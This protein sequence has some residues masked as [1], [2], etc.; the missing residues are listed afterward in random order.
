LLGA[1]FGVLVVVA[2]L[3]FSS[4]L[5]HLVSTPARYGWTW[6]L[7]GYDVKAGPPSG[8][9]CGPVETTLT[10]DPSF[11]G[12]VGVHGRRRGGRAPSAAGASS[13]CAGRCSPRSSPAASPV[14][15]GALGA[16][17]LAALDEHVG[18]H[19]RA[20]GES[21]SGTF[22]IV[23]QAVLSGISDPESMADGAACSPRRHSIGWAQAVAG[24]SVKLAGH[25]P[26]AAIRATQGAVLGGPITSTLPAEIDRVHQ[27]RSL[28]VA[29]AVFVAVIALVAVGLALVSSR[30]AGAASSRCS[31]HWA[32]RAGRYAPRSRQAS[33]VAAVGLVIG[34]PLG[35]L[36][37]T[38]VWR[39]VAEELGVAPDPCGRCSVSRCSSSAPSS[40]STCCRSAG[41]RRT[42]P[43][44]SRP[45]IGM[46]W[47]PASTT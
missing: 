27:I 9:D 1:A 18:G 16:E 43:P 22:R 33:T 6:D 11:S 28:P 20:A 3:M 15:R 42:H 31:R 38:F 24:T 2:V 4:G 7:V 21:E 14:R 26:R 29:L 25:R 40:P 37:G 44:R 5:E 46:T 47:S 39:Q 32:S 35:L 12:G 13:S 8:H 36:V 45:T 41:A 17:T 30:D 10:E 34:I 19:V 23:G